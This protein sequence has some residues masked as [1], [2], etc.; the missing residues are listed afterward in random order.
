MV[1]FDKGHET[2]RDRHAGRTRPTSGHADGDLLDIIR[3]GGDV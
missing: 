1:K 3:R 2:Q